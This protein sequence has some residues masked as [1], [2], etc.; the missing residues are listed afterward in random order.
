MQRLTEK[1]I[2]SDELYNQNCFDYLKHIKLPKD[3]EILENFG[4]KTRILIEKIG[5]FKNSEYEN[6]RL[7]SFGNLKSEF[8]RALQSD[9]KTIENYRT[10]ILLSFQH[11]HDNRRKQSL[12][13]KSKELKEYQDKLDELDAFID[14]IYNNN[15]TNLIRTYDLIKQ[16]SETQNPVLEKSTKHRIQKFFSDPWVT[17]NRKTPTKSET[18]FRRAWNTASPTFMPQIEGTNFAN[19]ISYPYASARQSEELRVDG[20]QVQRPNLNYQDHQIA[21]LYALWLKT[22]SKP[23]ILDNIHSSHALTSATSDLARN[24][25]SADVSELPET[26]LV[27][28][29]A[30]KISQA[31]GVERSLERGLSQA[32]YKLEQPTEITDPQRVIV[33]TL[34]SDEGLMQHETYLQ[35]TPTFASNTVIQNL[36]RSTENADIRTKAESDS[37][38]K[39]RKP[40]PSHGLQDFYISKRAQKLLFSEQLNNLKTQ[41]SDKSE[42]EVIRMAATEKYTELLKKSFTT[43]GFKVDQQLSEADQQAVWFHFIKFELTNFILDTLKP[44]IFHFTCKDAIDRGAVASAYFNLIKSFNENKPLTRDE[45]NRALQAPAAMVKARG[46]N[47]HLNLIWNSVDKYVN[48]NMSTFAADEQKRWLIAWRDMNCPP[49]LAGHVLDTYLKNHPAQGQDAKNLAEKILDQIK[50]LRQANIG[51]EKLL[52]TIFAMTKSFSTDPNDEE[53]LKRYQ[54]LAEKLPNISSRYRYLGGLMLDLVGWIMKKL[55]YQPEAEEY[56]NQGK[57]LKTSAY[58]AENLKKNLKAPNFMGKNTSENRALDN[59]TTQLDLTTTKTR[60]D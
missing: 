29:N 60:R 28:F 50:S 48:A 14:S 59:K 46:M 9:V 37:D 30:L 21:P 24:H 57:N 25:Q 56:F 36:I 52:L 58:L 19:K 6:V 53:T 54:Q 11:I 22:F 44:K 47:H 7:E 4:Q 34:P 15:N 43:L 45:F 33:I 26:D 1:P 12:E 39:K 3:E 8:S 32:L 10:N 42:D 41:H 51:D 18:R 2:S 17:L 5:K 23:P 20:T 27:Y 38:K 55:G 35:T 13:T 16:F 31:T 49:K 40:A